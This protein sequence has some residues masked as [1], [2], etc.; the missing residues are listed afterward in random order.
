MR[1]F[2]FLL[3]PILLLHAKE[4]YAK[5]EPYEVRTIASNVAGQVLF[6]DETKEGAMLDGEAFVILDDELDK[7]ELKSIAGKLELLQLT[8]ELNRKL[9][10]NYEE[11]LKRK[12]ENYE[13]IKDLKI[14]SSLEKDKEFYDLIASQNAL[15]GVE[16]EIASL[17]TQINDLLLRKAQ[18]ERSLRDKHLS[19]KG[20]VLYDLLVK[21]GQV[22][23]IATPLAKVADISKA[24]L[25]LY[26][27]QEDAASA[28][29]KV[30]YLN[31][32]KSGYAFARIWDIA[33]E[34]HLS[35]YKA[36]IIID[37]PKRFSSLIKVE[38]RDE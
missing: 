37:A 36:Q 27:S 32:K 31:G 1:T 30:L 5:A 16:K 33:D 9:Q 14:K 20:M 26:L 18:L 12:Q 17:Q 34:Q 28:K 2:F 21:E 3:L 35:S 6:A 7:T 24:M 11:T 8:L 10:V 25:T 29:Q 19:A 13:R 38:L 4:Y 22:V 23:T 15:I